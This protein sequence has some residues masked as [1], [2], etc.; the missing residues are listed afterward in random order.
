MII[1]SSFLYDR[2]YTW[3]QIKLKV[4]TFIFFDIFFWISISI[5]LIKHKYITEMP[6]DITLTFPQNIHY[7]TGTMCMYMHVHWIIYL[8]DSAVEKVIAF[9]VILISSDYAII[10]FSVVFDVYGLHTF[11]S[12]LF[13]NVR[14][15]YRLRIKVHNYHLNLKF[16]LN[17]N[18]HSDHT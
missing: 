4:T 5:S 7:V 18:N 15:G 2:S 9:L 3:R 13:C 17:Q 8:H 6:E 16:I 1:K 14:I 10:C 11:I 12:Q